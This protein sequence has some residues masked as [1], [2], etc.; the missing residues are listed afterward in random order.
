[1]TPATPRFD[2]AQVRR[3]YDRHT[4]AFLA[5]GRGGRVGAIHRPVWAPG[6]ATPE[7]AFHFVDEQILDLARKMA[8]AQGPLH[9]VDLGCGVG[10]SLCYLAGRLPIRATGITV[11]PVQARL[12]AGRAREAGVSDRVVCLEADFCNLPAAVEPADLAY[13]IESFAHVTAPARFFAECH[14]L[15]RPGGVLAICDDVRRAAGS[16]A[17][18]RTVG[19][20]CRGWHL[21]SLLR[22]DELISLAR[23]A[24]FDHQTTLDLSPWLERPRTLDRIVDALLGW[25]PLN[26]TR[27]GPVL[28]GTALLKCQER[29]W[30]GYELTVFRRRSA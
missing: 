15:V 3:Y 2:E 16:R 29:G 9:L 22:R 12:A 1:M 18:R 21:N 4:P 11:S 30:T 10:A 7:Q 19:R 24:G 23:A 28:G 6:V 27:L 5:F 26:R 25:L 8:A 20:F 17:A 14:R 13:A